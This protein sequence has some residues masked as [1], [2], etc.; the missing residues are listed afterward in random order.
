MKVRSNSRGLTEGSGSAHLEPVRHLRREGRRLLS[1]RGL[2]EGPGGLEEAVAAVVVH[3]QDPPL[4]Q[5]EH[6]P[7][8]RRVG[9]Q[10]LRAPKF[11]FDPLVKQ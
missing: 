9:L 6:S 2:Q 7:L 11:L 3:Q 8:H 10:V 5:Q 1:I 4:T